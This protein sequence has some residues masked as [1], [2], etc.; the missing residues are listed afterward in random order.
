MR[1]VTPL[2]V[3]SA[4][5]QRRRRL[6]ELVALRAYL[7]CVAAATSGSWMK[8][9]LE[10]PTRGDEAA[11]SEMLARIRFAARFPTGFLAKKLRIWLPAYTSL[12]L[13]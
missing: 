12:T 13:S 1:N 5:G 2:R 9:A 11:D 3:A 10:A 7:T 8:C 4:G 6:I